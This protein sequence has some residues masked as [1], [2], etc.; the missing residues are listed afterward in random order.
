MRIR[1]TMAGL[2]LVAV[3][4]LAQ[5]PDGPRPGGGPGPGRGR[6]GFGG[7]EMGARFIGAEAGMPGRVVKNAPYSAEVVTES[8]QTLP[9]GNR[10]RQS[11]AAKVY[12]DSEGRT[13]REQSVN[14]NGLTPNANMPQV[15]FIHDPV[16][17]VNLALNAK[18]RT[19][20]K[21]AWTRGA[22]RGMQMSQGPGPR[23]R[24]RANADGAPGG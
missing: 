12:R 16:A 19:A 8:T 24:E 3:G 22:G 23:P 20:T 17:G 1:T 2:L 13:R 21:T 6:M 9:D 4:A 10:I 11:T 7:P 15:V 5:G 14:L 18:D